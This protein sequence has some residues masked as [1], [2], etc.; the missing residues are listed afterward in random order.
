MVSGTNMSISIAFLRLQPCH[1]RHEQGCQ[2]EP[3][4]HMNRMKAEFCRCVAGKILLFL[5]KLQYA[6]AC[7]S[8]Y[9]CVHPYRCNH[10]YRLPGRRVYIGL[11]VDS[12]ASGFQCLLP[13]G[14]YA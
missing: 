14:L 4:Y 9:F 1:R 12:T 7:A 8:G 13:C 3:S 11:G 5:L 6:Q 2:Y 10:F